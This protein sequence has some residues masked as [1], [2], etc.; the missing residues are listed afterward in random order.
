MPTLP[1]IPP[2]QVP[3]APSSPPP[4]FPSASGFQPVPTTEPRPSPTPEEAAYFHLL[5]DVLGF[6]PNSPP[7]FS[8]AWEGINTVADL[9]TLEE[10]FF[11]QLVYFPRENEAPAYIPRGNMVQL[12]VL[13]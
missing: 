13:V 5:Q 3:A 8:L 12:Q 6:A 2:S 11:T 7:M 9:L 10:D 4:G 1:T